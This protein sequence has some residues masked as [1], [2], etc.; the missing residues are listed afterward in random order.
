[1]KREEAQEE[2]LLTVCKICV[3]AILEEISSLLPNAAAWVTVSRYARF[4]V[5]LPQRIYQVGAEQARIERQAAL[6]AD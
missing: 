3:A 2:I 4:R 1:V 5:I 6:A